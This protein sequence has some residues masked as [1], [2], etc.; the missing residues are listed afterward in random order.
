MPLLD[1]QVVSD[2][3]EQASRFN[4]PQIP[5]P[6]GFTADRRS[7]QH[8]S[9]PAEVVMEPNNQPTIRIG[10]RDQCFRRFA[11]FPPVNEGYASFTIKNAGRIGCNVWC[12]FK[13]SLFA[14]SMR[15]SSGFRGMMLGHV[16]AITSVAIAPSGWFQRDLTTR[17]YRLDASGNLPR[18]RFQLQVISLF[19]K[20]PAGQ[21]I[22]LARSLFADSAHRTED[23][24]WPHFGYD[25]TLGENVKPDFS[26]H[27]WKV[28]E[29]QVIGHL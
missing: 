3:T 26:S 20:A 16:G 24:S 19:V 17:A 11:L 29:R 2:C 27:G 6:S 7:L 13:W 8:S 22:A 14:L 25:I 18:S 9:V 5:V 4:R 21:A 15:R 1:D 23:R 28:Q 12:Q 10:H